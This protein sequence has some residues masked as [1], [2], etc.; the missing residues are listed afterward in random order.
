MGIKWRSLQFL[1]HISYS[2]YLTHTPIYGAAFFVGIKVLDDS[3]LSEAF[4]LLL[5]ILV[6]VGFAAIMW[7]FVEKPSIYLSQK[8]KLAKNKKV[9]CV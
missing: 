8:V 5:G 6:S 9:I 3:V 1:G 2:L 7:Q 4:C